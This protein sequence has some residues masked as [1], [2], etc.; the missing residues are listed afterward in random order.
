MNVAFFPLHEE[1]KGLQDL[2]TSAGCQVDLSPSGSQALA[3]DALVIAGED[4]HQALADYFSSARLDYLLDRRLAGGRHVLVVGS[5][6]H[7]LFENVEDL[8][9]GSLAQWPGNVNRRNFSEQHLRV[10]PSKSPLIGDL[11]GEPLSFPSAYAAHT[12]PATLLGP[13]PLKPPLTTMAT[14]QEKLVAAVENGALV[15][16]QFLPHCSGE[17]GQQIISK[18]LM[19]VREK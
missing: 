3:A 9:G 1:A 18:W 15:G 6:M 12:D 17:V 7:L 5:P 4:S 10:E 14:G 8:E 11:N 16:L 2:L 19:R 13:G